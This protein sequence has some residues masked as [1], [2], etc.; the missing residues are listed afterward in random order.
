MIFVCFG[1]FN[2]IV[3]VYIENTLNAAKTEGEKSRAQRQHESVRVARLARQ[4]LK[5]FLAAQRVLAGHTVDFDSIAL[6]QGLSSSFDDVAEAST[7]ISK[8]MFLSTIQDSSVQRLMDDLD[9]PP[10]RAGL[11]DTLDSD[12]SGGLQLEELITGLLQVRG[13]PKKSDVVGILLAVRKV[14]EML[15]DQA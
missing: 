4:L 1:L 15:R 5:K 2:L 14:Q 11:F 7:P 8:E 10:E 13:E 9:I 12:G 6:H 3:A